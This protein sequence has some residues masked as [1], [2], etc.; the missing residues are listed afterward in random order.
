MPYSVAVTV[1]SKPRKISL[2]ATCQA[3]PETEQECEGD[4]GRGWRGAGAA[5]HCLETRSRAALMH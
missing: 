2:S 5:S 4:A 3:L 1:H